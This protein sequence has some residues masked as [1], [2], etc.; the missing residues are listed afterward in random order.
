MGTFQC[1]TCP[2]DWGRTR[3][4]PSCFWQWHSKP[5]FRL[6]V[7]ALAMP[8]LPD[9]PHICILRPLSL[10]NPQPL[11]TRLSSL[12]CAHTPRSSLSSIAVCHLETDVPAVARLPRLQKAPPF[13]RCCDPPA[14]WDAL[15]PN[16]RC[17][18]T[19]SQSH[20]VADLPPVVR[21][22]TLVHCLVPVTLDGC[23]AA[24]A[25]AVLPAPSPA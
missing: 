21:F 2:G 4:S 24:A 10:C 20:A 1:Q 9:V 22:H 17:S 6:D 13:A 12:P 7:C 18:A 8:L 11:F 14:V 25:E 3:S 23:P 15:P 19:P 16:A 5:S